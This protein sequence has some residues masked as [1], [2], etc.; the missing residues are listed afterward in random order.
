MPEYLSIRE[1]I[2]RQLVLVL[3]AAPGV[4]RVFRW[5]GRGLRDPETG[6]ATDASGGRLSMQVGDCMLI[7]LDERAEEGGEGNVGY[8]LKTLPVDV[9]MKVAAADDDAEAEATMINRCLLNLETALMVDPGVTERHNSASGGDIILAIDMRTTGNYQAPRE[10]GQRETIVALALEVTYQ[11]QRNNPAAG[12]GI[13]ARAVQSDMTPPAIA[14][15]ILQPSH[16]EIQIHFTE[17]SDPVRNHAGNSSGQLWDPSQFVL[18]QGTV[19]ATSLFL[20]ASWVLSL[21]LASPAVPTLVTWK[22]NLTPTAAGAV[23]AGGGMIYDGA[24]P[25]D[26][27]RS[28]FSVAIS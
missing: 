27:G 8:T 22:A 18:D 23:A 10:V 21:S 12:P 11:H 9:Q 16:Q 24:T 25:I 17:A 7:P 4:N 2:E 15:A 1:R 6:L 28:T 13:T 14:S 19:T 20:G 3:Q 26:N 5:D